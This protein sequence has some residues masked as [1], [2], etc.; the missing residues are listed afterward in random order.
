MSKD[1]DQFDL[2]E[3]NIKIKA[4]EV[5]QGFCLLYQ[6]G[7][8]SHKSAEKIIEQIYKSS[9]VALGVCPNPHKDWLKGLNEIHESFRGK[10]IKD[11]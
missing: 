6:D 9:H 2:R 4:L 1:F 5:I 3:K 11:E 8:R 10:Y 7:K